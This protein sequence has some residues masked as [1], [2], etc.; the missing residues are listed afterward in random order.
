MNRIC[1]AIVLALGLGLIVSAE[2]VAHAETVVPGEEHCVVS[3]RSSDRLN[4]RAR[5]SARAAVLAQ[6]RY[7]EC[8]ILVRACVGVWCKI[9]DGH[10]LGWVH[11]RYISMISPAMY[12]VTALAP[13]D[14]LNVR[15]FPSPRSQVLTRLPQHRCEIAFLPYARGTWQKIR[16]NGWQGWVNRRYL[17]GE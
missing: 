16:V 6:K 5:P 13:G 10:N 17:S 12:C 14:R 2:K 11:R 3:V 4:L 8:G 9:E 1:H 15:A 7:D